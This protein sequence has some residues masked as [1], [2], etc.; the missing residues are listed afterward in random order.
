MA[1]KRQFREVLP[2]LWMRAGCLGPRPA[3]PVSVPLPPWLI[4]D[5]NRFAVL[6]EEARFR[7]F[8][9]LARSRNDLSHVFLVTDSEDAFQ[10]MAAELPSGPEPVQLYR[11]YLEN[12]LINRGDRA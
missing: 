2:L 1:L 6:L 11:D 10:E 3:V 5:A 12:F 9:P 4:P 7:D 8:L